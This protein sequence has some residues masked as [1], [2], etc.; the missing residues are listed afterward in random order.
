M[1]STLNICIGSVFT[2]PNGTVLTITGCLPKIK[3][4]EQKYTCTCSECRKDPELFPTPFEVTKN[5]LRKGTIPCGCS[6]NTRW[7]EYQYKL[8]VQRECDNKGYIFHA[9]SG[10]YNK[11]LTKLLLENPVTGNVWKTANIVT[12][13]SNKGN[14]PKVGRLRMGELQR[15][16]DEQHITDFIKAGFSDK[17]KFFK[18]CENKQKWGYECHV[19]STDEYVK[20]NLCDGVFTSVAGDLKN[21]RRSC[22]CSANYRWSRLQREYQINKI[23]EEEDLTFVGWCG[24]FKGNKSKFK[25][26]CSKGHINKANISNF[27]NGGSRCKTCAELAN[28]WGYFPDRVDEEDSLY[29]LV[30]NEDSETFI[31]VGRSFD[32]VERLRV[33]SRHY[34]NVNII[35]TYKNTH[36]FIYDTEQKIHKQLKSLNYHYRP[37]ISFKGS[38]NECFTIDSLPLAKEIFS[39]LN[40]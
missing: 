37:V 19:C 15:Y 35:K 27:I 30:F 9:W 36:Q 39:N 34:T 31:K 29:L 1:N 8:R 38:K 40:K 2:R 20:Y 18:C 17:D 21:G 24:D 28:E 4:K 23:C 32:I 7:S 5:S 22:R 12:F 25:W 3:G 10:K 33:F 26:R 11:K 14:D 16:S 6:A 13:L